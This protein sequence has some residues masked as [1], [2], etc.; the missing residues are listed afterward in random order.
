MEIYKPKFYLFEGQTGGKYSDQSFQNILRAAVL[1]SVVDENTSV[2]K[3]R[4]TFATH[5]I[6]NGVDL[7][8]VQEYLEHSS[9]ESTAIY[10]HIT[11]KMRSGIK[12]PLVGLDTG[13]I[14]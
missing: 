10:T 6:L 3:L 4:H 12:S 1:K 8:R 2:H 11:D 7:R 14:C 9:L 5:M 13:E